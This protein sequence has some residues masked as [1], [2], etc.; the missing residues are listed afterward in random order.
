MIDTVYRY[1]YLYYLSFDLGFKSVCSRSFLAGSDDE[2]L[3]FALENCSSF[4][5]DVSLYRFARINEY[6][7]TCTVCSDFKF[8]GKVNCIES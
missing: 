6:F 7:D 3:G 1:S 2:A 5:S 8:L 4:S